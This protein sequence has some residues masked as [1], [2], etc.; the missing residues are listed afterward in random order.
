[1]IFSPERRIA[2]QFPVFKMMSGVLLLALLCSCETT[3]IN[4]AEGPAISNST[5]HVVANRTRHRNASSNSVK[6]SANPSR[7]GQG[8]SATYTVTSTRVNSTSAITVNYAMTGT[9]VQGNHYTLSGTAGRAIIP[10]GASSTA[11]ALTATR[12]SL[13]SGTKTATMTIRSGT[14]YNVSST[15]NKATI[16]ISYD[17]PTPTPTPSPTPAPTPTP[18][19]TPTPI[20]GTSPTP[21]AR[22]APTQQVW[23]A[24]RTDGQAGTGTQS[25]P[26]DG[27][28]QARFD[29]VMY[30]LRNTPNL[31]INIGPGTF[32]TAA[33][34]TNGYAHTWVVQ[35]GW[36][37]Q[38]SG[39]D[40]TI[41][42][43]VGSVAGIHY[44]LT[45]FTAPPQGSTDNVTLSDF[46]VDCNWAELSQTA[47]TGLSGEK[48]INTGAVY[49]YG[50]NNV[51]QRV[52][53]ISSF[54]SWANA[55][56]SFAI[57]L[58]SPTD[59]DA[60]GNTIQLC[61]SEQPQGN[62]CS[63]FALHGRGAHLIMNSS[64]ILSSAAGVQ[65]G[66][67]HVFVSGGV[68]GANVK[69]CV[70]D[71]ND[72][73]D[74]RSIYYQ[75]TGS[76]DGVTV[77]NNTLLRGWEG[78]GLDIQNCVVGGGSYFVSINYAPTTNVTISNNHTTF[79]Q[80]GNGM[81]QFWSV[82]AQ[83]LINSTISNNS[84]N[85]DSTGMLNGTN[86]TVS[87]NRNADASVPT[88]L[89]DGVH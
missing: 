75:D 35:P 7:I 50:S 38:G 46:T 4:P 57:T 56:E 3:S 18:P 60:S 71:S 17:P 25:D 8:S 44:G 45:C 14:G 73:V 72:F 16:T 78:V 54:G 42:Q 70:V 33:A 24:I 67:K 20:P 52:K 37:V 51:V 29:A 59:S 49:L 27:S 5:S 19:P 9:A 10:A 88:G 40:V 74:C 12:T 85:F 79:D 68:N 11:V 66:L 55:Q 30:Q 23:I 13:T 21:V 43:M 61:R 28:T 62:Y 39:I 63:P 69:D 26:Y 83:G 53:S 86:I 58:A 76:T 84:F 34:S 48:N 64:V 77:I 22:T 65:D 81:V 87:N 82:Q 80:T 89:A 6:V 47:D 15:S 2:S 1:M 32:K 36:F 41:I 31:A